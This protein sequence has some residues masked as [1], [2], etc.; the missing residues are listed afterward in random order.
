M[1]FFPVRFVP[2]LAVAASLRVAGSDSSLQ[3]AYRAQHLLGPN[4]WTRVI[5]VRN[6]APSSR[7]PAEVDAV[8]FQVADILWFY[9]DRDGTQSLS[10]Y[11][12]RSESDKG[13]LGPLLLGIDRGFV[14]W[15]DAPPL[16]EALKHE[17][18]IPNGCFIE[19]L[20][21]LRQRREH[22]APA[23]DARLLSYYVRLPGGLHGHTVLQFRTADGWRVVDPH[24][25]RRS[26]SIRPADPDD[27]VACARALR[28]E[29]ASARFLPLTATNRA[30]FDRQLSAGPRQATAGMAP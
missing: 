19:S 14:A 10:Q 9:S 3:N 1:H 8:I 13:N 18:R 4:I 15:A 2:L 30:D 22:G 16:P 29:I 21:L 20:A 17:G 28:P 12:H 5:R 23:E 26:L 6:A 11:L 25:P 24:F 7:Y 27:P